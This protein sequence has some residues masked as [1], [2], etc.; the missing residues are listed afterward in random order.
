MDV[1]QEKCDGTTAVDAVFSGIFDW[2]QGIISGGSYLVLISATE[3]RA[4][5]LDDI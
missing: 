1:F 3:V 2:T 5:G 4:C